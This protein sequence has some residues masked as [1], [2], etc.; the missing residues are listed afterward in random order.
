M[1]LNTRRVAK[2][3]FYSRPE[4]THGA[5]RSLNEKKKKWNC[6]PRVE[7][8]CIPDTWGNALGLI[9][10]AGVEWTASPSSPRTITIVTRRA[11]G[12]RHFISFRC[13]AERLPLDIALARDA[14]LRTYIIHIHI[15]IIS[16]IFYCSYF[17]QSIRRRRTIYGRHDENRVEW[18]SNASP[19]EFKGHIFSNAS[20]L[21]S[22]LHIT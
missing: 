13:H 16:D 18:I 4:T 10:H 21:Y 5:T 12:S 22:L 20:L 17:Y 8:A 14:T 15:Y 11:G 6:V 3:K 9:S 7:Q 2:L 19:R 1:F